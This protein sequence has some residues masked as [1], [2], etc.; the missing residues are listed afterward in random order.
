MARMC[1]ALRIF[2]LM[3]NVYADN[4]LV[5]AKAGQFVTFKIPDFKVA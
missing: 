3:I 5:K 1:S 2:H 4:A